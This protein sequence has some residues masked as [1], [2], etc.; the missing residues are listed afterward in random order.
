MRVAIVDDERTFAEQVREL[1]EAC[2]RGQEEDYEVKTYELPTE[3]LWDLQEGEYFD[4]YL[5]DVDFL[6]IYGGGGV[7]G[8]TGGGNTGADGRGKKVV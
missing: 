3:L 4:V 1:A 5:L 2:L 6:W 7:C 8:L